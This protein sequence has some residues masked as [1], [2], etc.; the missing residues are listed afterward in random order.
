MAAMRLGILG[1]ADIAHRRFLPALSAVPGLTLAAI[2]SRDPRRADAAAHRYGCAAV[3]GYPALLRRG[4]VDAVYVPLPAAVHARWARAALQAGK[5]VLVEKPIAQSAA[6][7]GELVS[8][9]RARG[10]AV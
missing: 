3:S 6:R 2:A 4:D 8:L 9:A 10:L 5:H 1:C 7:A